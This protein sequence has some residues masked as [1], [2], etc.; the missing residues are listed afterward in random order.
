MPGTYPKRRM[1][2]L[3]PI[4]ASCLPLDFAAADSQVTWETLVASTRSP[5]LSDTLDK[6]NRR[7]NA[8]R[9]VSDRENWR[10][11]DYWATPRELLSRGA[12]DCEDFAIAKYFLLRAD[13]VP[14]GA[15][16]LMFA[17]VYSPRQ[18]KIEAHLVLLYRPAGAAE[19]LVLDNLRDDIVK[20]SD[21]RDLLP[22]A[23]F[24][25]DNYWTYLNGEWLLSQPASDMIAWHRLME[26]W[27]RQLASNQ[28]A[29]AV[30]GR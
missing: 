18:M 4:L 27:N 23:G 28:V 7:V 14:P 29:A 1:L 3:L 30:T 25:T 13:G 24:D 10:Q 2:A 22:R 5:V 19:P 17:R 16:R 9:A 26:R 8:F 21:R 6:V 15:L 12:G 11:A 20:L